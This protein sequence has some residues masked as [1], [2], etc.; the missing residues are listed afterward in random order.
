MFT[1]GSGT[2]KTLS[3]LAAVTV[4]FNPHATIGDGHCERKSFQTSTGA[5][6]CGLV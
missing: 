4:L 3:V 1:T 2:G 6:F 5:E